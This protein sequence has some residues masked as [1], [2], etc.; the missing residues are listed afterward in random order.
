[1]ETNPRETLYILNRSD[2]DRI[3]AAVDLLSQVIEDLTEARAFHV[4]REPF[5]PGA[6]YE[7]AEEA[8]RINEERKWTGDDTPQADMDF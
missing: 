2:R 4:P 3:L 7:L 8:D 1:M 5:S 6:L